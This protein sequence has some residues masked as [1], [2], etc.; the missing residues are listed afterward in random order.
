MDKQIK[1]TGCCELID[2]DAW[3]GKEMVWH[4]K[5]F[6]TDHITSFLHMPLNFGSQMTKNMKL[7]HDAG[8]EMK[9]QLTLVDEHSLW[10]AELYISIPKEIVGARTAKISGTFLT[11]VFEGPYKDA[12]KWVKEMEEY[13]KRKGKDLKKIYFFYTVCPTCAKAYGKNYVVLFAQVE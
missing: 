13:V 7:I 9:D 2:P 5:L 11:K 4:D 10:G 1:S 12:G 8:A 6:A 3:Q